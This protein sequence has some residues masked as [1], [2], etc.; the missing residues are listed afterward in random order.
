M[1]TQAM[2]HNYK[3]I[4]DVRSLEFINKEL[5]YD[6]IPIISEEKPVVIEKVKTKKISSKP[7]RNLRY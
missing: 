4:M 2:Y 7:L 1:L 6:F 3:D 5:G